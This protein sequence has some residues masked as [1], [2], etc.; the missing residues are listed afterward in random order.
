M[1]TRPGAGRNQRHGAGG[2][3]T[4]DLVDLACTVLAYRY[5]VSRLSPLAFGLWAPL[6][7]GQTAI[8][9]PDNGL[10]LHP[11]DRTPLDHARSTRSLVFGPPAPCLWLRPAPGR[12]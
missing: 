2:P 10:P 6:S 11:S 3:K 4:S 1:G 12:V 5:P 8:S 7:F 9:P